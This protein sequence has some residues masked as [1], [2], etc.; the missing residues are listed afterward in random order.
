MTTT[1]GDVGLYDEQDDDDDAGWLHE[2]S[3]RANSFDYEEA[4][5][6]AEANSPESAVPTCA[7]ARKGDKGGTVYAA[8]RHVIERTC[9]T[10]RIPT[11]VASICQAYARVASCITAERTNGDAVMRT[12]H[13]TMHP[14]TGALASVGFSKWVATVNRRRYMFE[15]VRCGNTDEH[16]MDPMLL[17]ER[18][19]AFTGHPPAGCNVVVDGVRGNGNGVGGIDV[20]RVYQL[21]YDI[22]LA[23]LLPKGVC[24]AHIVSVA[25]CNCNMGHCGSLRQV[26]VLRTLDL[27]TATVGDVFTALGPMVTDDGDAPTSLSMS[28]STSTSKT[29]TTT[30]TNIA[31]VAHPTKPCAGLTCECGECFLGYCRFRI[32]TQPRAWITDHLSSTCARDRCSDAFER[33]WKATATRWNDVSNDDVFIRVNR[34]C[35]R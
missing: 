17:L 35:D 28:M 26:D 34:G 9:A 27:C 15:S 22:R 18:L 30:T 31:Y 12:L 29:K 23:S 21:V 8:T 32:Q 11:D 19:F 6:R 14:T 20:R 25:Y 1:A 33:D 7:C 10:A 4:E 5:R 3:A 2:E 16:E 13:L 24:R